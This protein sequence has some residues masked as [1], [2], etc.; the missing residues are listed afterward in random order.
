MVSGYEEV[1]SAA[2]DPQ[3]FC[4]RHDLPNGSSPYGGVMVPSTPVRAV[5]I[6]VDPPEYLFYRRLLGPRFTPTTVRAMQPRIAQFIDWCIDRRI[7]SGRIDLFHDLAKLVPAMTTMHLLGLP[8]EDAEII[9]DAVHVRG[10]D[11]FTVKPAWALLYKHT[12]D[13][14]AARRENPQ[15]DLISYLLSADIDGRKFTDMELYELCFTM[16]IGGMATTARLTLGGLS[17][18]AVHEDQRQRLRDDRSLMPDAI[19][20]FLRYYSPVPFLSRTATVDTCLGGQDIKAGDRVVLGYAAANRDPKVF[21]E[22]N[23]IRLDR[24]PNKHLAL[25][26]GLHFCI[27]GLLGKMEATMMIERVLDRL[28]DYRLAGYDR[29]GTPTADAGDRSGERLGAAWE[30]RT[31]RG[32]P[33]DFT[34]GPVVG[35]DAGIDEFAQLPDVLAKTAGT[36][37]TLAVLAGTAAASARA[38]GSAE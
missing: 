14:I 11:R 30:V 35:A 32:L 27:G 16:V 28:P 38:T 33:V 3:T 20:E 18:L 9:A 23:E 7:E 31:D 21:D 6:E 37:A 1:A 4:S 15:D 13:S 19:E 36:L 29:T 17:Y 8:L 2:R 34:P 26:Q 24:S 22:P 10:E 12:N 5:P 25:G